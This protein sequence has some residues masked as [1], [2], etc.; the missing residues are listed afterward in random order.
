V[1]ILF[2]TGLSNIYGELSLF[3]SEMA[4]SSTMVCGCSDINVFETG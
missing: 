1:S 3:D 2:F 4:T